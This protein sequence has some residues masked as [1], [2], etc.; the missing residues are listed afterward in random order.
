MLRDRRYKYVRY[1]SYPPQLFD[2]EADPEEL[3]DLADDP[4]HAAVLAAME[5]R[6]RG[7]LDPEAVDRAVKARQAELI[8]AHGGR[9]AVLARGDLSYSPPPGVRPDWG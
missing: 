5:A 8:E 1:V 6:L 9:A 4:A 7:I 2:L 3:R